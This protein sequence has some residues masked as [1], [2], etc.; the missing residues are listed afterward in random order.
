MT[1]TRTAYAVVSAC[2]RTVSGRPATADGRLVSGPVACIGWASHQSAVR[3]CKPVLAH[4]PLPRQRPQFR[5]RRVRL[6]SWP[7]V[8]FTSTR[9]GGLSRP[10]QDGHLIPEG[11]FYAY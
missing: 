6:G 7:Y 3:S 1:R 4:R 9:F 5:A 8:R 10:A 11:T 2:A